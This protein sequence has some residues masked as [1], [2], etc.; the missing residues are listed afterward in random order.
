MPY[1][2]SKI[3]GKINKRLP[4]YKRNKYVRNFLIALLIILGS[5]SITIRIFGV[6]F[7][8]AF[9]VA[10]YYKN[11]EMIFWCILYFINFYISV[12]IEEIDINKVI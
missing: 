1:R 4:I 2:E 12:K 6:I 7:I 9:P 5:I 8:F 3:D 10:L 11:T